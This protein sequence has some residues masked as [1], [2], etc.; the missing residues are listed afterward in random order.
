M[1]QRSEK[2]RVARRDHA[3]KQVRVSAD[4]LRHGLDGHIGAEHKWTLI[5]GR[6]KRIVHAQNRAGL[7]RCGADDVQVS[8]QQQRVRW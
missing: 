4:E 1:S 5:E 8:H 3:A 6:G 7:P 2:V